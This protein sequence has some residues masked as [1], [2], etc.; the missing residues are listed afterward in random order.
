MFLLGTRK[1][2][3]PFRPC[4]APRSEQL[5]GPLDPSVPPTLLGKSVAGWFLDCQTAAWLG[6]SCPQV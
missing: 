1:A 4:K 6:S 5:S 2:M 3:A